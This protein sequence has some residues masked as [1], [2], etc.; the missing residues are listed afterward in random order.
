MKIIKLLT[1]LLL[2][3]SLSECRQHKKQ[4]K[5]NVKTYKIANTT[6]D[7]N[8]LND[9]I[10]W[11]VI[12]QPNNSCSYYCT[13][14]P[15]V[16]NNFTTVNWTPSNTIPSTISSEKPVEEQE[17]ETENFSEEMQ[18]EID[19][20]P[21]NFE[22]M[23]ESEMGDYENSSQPGDAAPDTESNSSS[24]SNSGSDSGSDGGDA[25][26]SGGD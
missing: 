2:M 7:N 9:F 11:Y 17:V 16:N 23:T 6:V 12:L 15:I 22:G 4:K 26:G 5:L 14:T 8:P 19:T 24:E 13:T 21:E 25:G 20:T 10:F 1:L 3:L 18:A